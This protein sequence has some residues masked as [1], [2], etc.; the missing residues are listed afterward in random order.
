[1]D[2]E[3]LNNI[4]FWIASGILGSIILGTIIYLYKAIKDNQEEIIKE[5]KEDI[6]K[7]P[8][9]NLDKVSLKFSDMNDAEVENAVDDHNFKILD[10]FEK[11]SIEDE[12]KFNEITNK[13]KKSFKNFRRL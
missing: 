2:R 3:T 7:G 8:S 12:K 1:M 11:A 6:S 10:D 5:K 4:I 9:F 13:S